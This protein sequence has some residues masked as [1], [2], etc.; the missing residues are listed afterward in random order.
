MLVAVRSHIRAPFCRGC[1]P[2]RCARWGGRLFLSTNQIATHMKRMTMIASLWMLWCLTMISCSGGNQGVKESDITGRYVGV[3]NYEQ[4]AFMIDESGTGYESAHFPNSDLTI[5][6]PF[7]WKLVGNS[8]TLTFDLEETMITGDTE[9]QAV[10]AIV[11]SLLS[12]YNE[13]R[14]YTVKRENGKVIID[15]DDVYPTYRQDDSLPD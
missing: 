6:T 14:T 3:G 12:G 5:L 7:T 2:C 8:L 4:W 15:G 10:E 9:D 13:P 11:T 1:V